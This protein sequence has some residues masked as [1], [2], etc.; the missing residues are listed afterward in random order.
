MPREFT[1][2]DRLLSFSS[3]RKCH[4]RWWYKLFIM[5]VPVQVFSEVLTPRW[6]EAHTILNNQN[7]ITTAKHGGNKQ[8]KKA[9][10]ERVD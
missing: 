7:K 3:I 8:N 2:S 5:F 4:W 9:V 1:L 10:L 6:G